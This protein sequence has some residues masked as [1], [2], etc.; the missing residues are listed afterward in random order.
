[1]EDAFAVM[2]NRYNLYNDSN[3]E[4][5]PVSTDRLRAMNPKYRRKDEM[6]YKNK[7]MEKTQH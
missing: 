6:K 4:D 1:V 3:S 5:T 2:S 7:V